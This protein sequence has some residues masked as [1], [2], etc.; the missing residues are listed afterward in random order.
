MWQHM[1]TSNMSSRWGNF[2]ELHILFQGNKHA[3][4]AY[5]ME[6]ERGHK[7]DM[8]LIKGQVCWNYQIFGKCV[9]AGLEARL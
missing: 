1:D 8:S 6:R 9:D 2:V 4:L 7:L 5:N 3:R